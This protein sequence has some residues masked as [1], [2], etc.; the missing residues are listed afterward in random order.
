[1][2]VRGLE[3][4]RAALAGGKGAILCSAHFGSPKSCFSLIGALGYP[5]T[6]VAR[7]S[8]TASGAEGSISRLQYA[9]DHNIPLT[10][11]LRRPN[12]ERMPGSIDTAV[13]AA[14]VLRQN[15]VVGIM[16]DDEVEPGDRSRP[17]PLDFLNGKALLV[18]GATTIAQLTGAPVL[19]M[20]MRRSVDWR[21]QV[22][23]IFPPIPIEGDPVIAF[24][25]CLALVEDA[26]KRYP[27]QWKKL[28]LSHLVEM[29][30][31]SHEVASSRPWRTFHSE[32]A[33]RQR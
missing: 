1:M 29:G 5:I 22:L 15:E 17:V 32:D 6:I 3:N 33:V 20:L 4:L 28:K 12:I 23:E 31:I 7:W 2:E 27:A 11:H 30:L 8:F 25:R 10:S 26:I 24:R 19:V 21:H 14:I 16:I 13:Q 9:L 18:P